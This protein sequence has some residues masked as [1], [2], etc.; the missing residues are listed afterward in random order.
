[1]Q[2]FY[3]NKERKRLK[4]T[5]SEDKDTYLWKFLRIHSL[6]T[7]RTLLFKWLSFY[8][9]FLI[10]EL[11]K[12]S[13]PKHLQKK[14]TLL[15]CIHTPCLSPSQEAMSQLYSAWLSLLFSNFYWV[16]INSIK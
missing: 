11:L 10:Y 16:E 12:N 7:H 2:D 8:L 14:K 1:M 5:V 9:N 6:S 4:R 13:F 15:S 3:L